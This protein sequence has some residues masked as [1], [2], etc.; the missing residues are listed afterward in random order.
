LLDKTTYYYVVTAS[1]AAGPS[2]NSNE[3][4]AKTQ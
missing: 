1:N 3:A 4:S 2:G